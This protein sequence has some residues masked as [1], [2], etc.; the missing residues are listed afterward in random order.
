MTMP[1]G[2]KN[3]GA[4]YQRC[5]QNCFKKQIG[6]NVHA[7]VDDVVIKSQKGDSL[8]AGDFNDWTDFTSSPSSPCTKYWTMHFDGSRQLEGLG[9]GDV[10]TSPKGD[11]LAYVLQ[12]HFNCTN[13]REY[14]Q[15]AIIK[16]I[17]YHISRS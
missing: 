2:L 3:A 9:S 10:L 4:T 5:I 11:K 17:N 13:Y 1:F 6:R 15:E 16:V 14:A 8:I 12:L 7:Y